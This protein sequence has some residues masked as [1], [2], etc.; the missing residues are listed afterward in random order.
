M[1]IKPIIFAVLVATSLS[2]TVRG[3]TSATTEIPESA[4]T[5]SPLL[6][7]SLVPEVI[8]KTSN[9]EAFDLRQHSTEKPSVLVFYRGGWC[10]FCNR[11]L[12]GLGKI[13]SK[14]RD[15]G[16]QILAISPDRPAKLAE[17]L[18]KTNI[19]YTL[20]SDHRM[21]A[22]QA[23]GIAFQLDKPT[24]KMLANYKIDIE[25][26]SGETHHQLPVPS[27][28]IVGRDGRIGFTY[29]NPDYKVR[30]DADVMLAA[31]RAV[32]KQ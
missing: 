16:Y 29:V 26:A 17:S 20:L 18:D 11:H 3:E 10:P 13:E 12:A 21:Q 8:L 25:D 31:A 24:L 32:L 15:L 28:F 5:V 1:K 30:L 23:F 19:S 6:I 4:Q 9:G 22:A 7:G 27:V 2:Y 14:L